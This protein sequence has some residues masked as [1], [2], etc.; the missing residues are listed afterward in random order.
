M[1]GGGEG[2]GKR[3]EEFGYRDILGFSHLL[4]FKESERLFLRLPILIPLLHG[5]QIL[6]YT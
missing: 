6:K 1:R 3:E 4:L 2:F 5:G